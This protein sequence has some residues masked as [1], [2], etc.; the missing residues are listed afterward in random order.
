MTAMELN[1][2]LARSE[3]ADTLTA[4]V[5]RSKQSNG[6]DDAFMA[7]CADELRV[8]PARIEKGNFWVA[9]A[10]GNLRGCVTLDPDAA[11]G[12]GTISTF[13][14]DPD[15]KRQG[16]GRA[17]WQVVQAAARAQGLLLLKL[18][19]DPAAVPFYEAMGF[20]TVREVPSGS[21]PG[22]VLPQ[23]ELALLPAA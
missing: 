13:F 23:M 20:K 16:V 18:D 14:I 17:L 15:A 21:I 22:R 10:Q 1:L 6:Y 3:E 5:M 7:A 9:E 11:T 12:A 4:L 2:R 19:A 8:T